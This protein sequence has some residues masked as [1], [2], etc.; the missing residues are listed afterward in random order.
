MLAFA[1]ECRE[2]LRGEDGGL[3]SQGLGSQG[4]E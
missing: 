3:G 2:S 1:I 4:L